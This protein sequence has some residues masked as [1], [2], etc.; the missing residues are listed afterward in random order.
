MKYT[1]NFKEQKFRNFV[2]S[3]VRVPSKSTVKSLNFLPQHEVVLDLEVVY[4]CESLNSILYP[5]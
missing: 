2:N 3:T 4:I 5:L 1:M